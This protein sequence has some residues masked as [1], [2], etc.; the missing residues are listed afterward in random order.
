NSKWVWSIPVL[1]FAGIGIYRNNRLKKR[2]RQI[3]ESLNKEEEAKIRKAM[4]TAA[5]PVLAHPG[6]FGEAHRLLM[7]GK[8]GGLFYEELA[9]SL[10]QFFGDRFSIRPSELNQNTVTHHL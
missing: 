7:E 6:P 2:S 8:N 10:W 4:E 3:S 1:A 9:R 5:S